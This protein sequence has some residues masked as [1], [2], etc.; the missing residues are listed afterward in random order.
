[1]VGQNIG[2]GFDKWSGC[3]AAWYSEKKD[4]IYNGTVDSTKVGHYTQVRSYAISFPHV[5]RS[6]NACILLSLDQT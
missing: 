4:F 2:N 6:G 1:M 5:L 3:I